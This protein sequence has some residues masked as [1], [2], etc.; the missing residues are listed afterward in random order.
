MREIIWESFHFDFQNVKKNDEDADATTIDYED[1]IVEDLQSLMPSPENMPI[2]QTSPFGMF[3]VDD[4]MNPFRNFDFWIGHT[5]F[6]IDKKVAAII[7]KCVGIETLTILTRYR[8]I[9]GVG[10]C[11]H[12]R[13]VRVELKQLLCHGDE[14]D[15]LLCLIEN[16]DI[17]QQAENLREELSQNKCWAIYIL[18]NGQIDHIVGETEDDDYIAKFNLFEQSSELTGGLIVTNIMNDYRPTI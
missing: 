9:I 14:T 7:E 1:S 17:R 12:I 13:K 3:R 11:F 8:F 6:D 16:D 4:S 18:P 2:I 15:D 10:K 5:N